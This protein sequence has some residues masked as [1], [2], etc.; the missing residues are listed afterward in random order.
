MGPHGNANRWFITA[1]QFFGGAGIA[2]ANAL[3]KIS[4]G[5]CVRQGKDPATVQEAS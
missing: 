2:G 3:E 4:E 1:H 5:K